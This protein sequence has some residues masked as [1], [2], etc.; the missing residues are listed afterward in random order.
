MYKETH[1][2][3]NDTKE[4]TYA[5]NQF[6]KKSDWDGSNCKHLKKIIREIIDG[7]LATISNKNT[8]YYN[9]IIVQIKKLKGDIL[10][11]DTS[12]HKLFKVSK[13]E[14]GG[15]KNNYDVDD[16]AQLA[17]AIDKLKASN[18]LINKVLG[19]STKQIQLLSKDLYSGVASSLGGYSKSIVEIQNEVSTIKSKIDKIESDVANI[20]KISEGILSKGDI[21]TAV[22]S[23]LSKVLA[24]APDKSKKSR[25]QDKH[26]KTIDDSKESTA[27]GTIID[28]ALSGDNFEN[29]EVINNLN[30]K[31]AGEHRGK[32]PTS[33]IERAKLLE[34]ELDNF[35][36]INSGG[37]KIKIRELQDEFDCVKR[38]IIK[39][40]KV[41]KKSVHKPNCN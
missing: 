23:E 37:K 4:L 10:L 34:L 28:R 41:N 6:C 12:I 29:I 14:G 21:V 5:L 38:D 8:E 39:G 32:L 17:N 27:D 9:D 3:Y 7:E 33:G 40:E 2:N 36:A 13:L 18:N 30:I 19:D 35:N 16:V 1:S 15:G 24:S 20:I 25:N 11:V 31:C 26:T 22:F